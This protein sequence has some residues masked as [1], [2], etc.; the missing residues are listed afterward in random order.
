[1]IIELTISEDTKNFLE[2]RRNGVTQAEWDANNDPNRP[3]FIGVSVIAEEIA[4]NYITV[5]MNDEKNKLLKE[6]QNKLQVKSLSQIAI[7]VA[8]L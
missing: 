3:A 5:A 7:D 8:G 6:A 2:K 1:M 4:T